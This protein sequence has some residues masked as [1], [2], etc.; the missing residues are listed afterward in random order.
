MDCAISRDCHLCTARAA[1]LVCAECERALPRLATGSRAPLSAFA[2][3]FPV[4]R[5]VQRFKFGGDL[6]VG[7]WLAEALAE[8][9]AAEPR[10]DLLVA[11]PLS[12]ARLR[13]RGFNQSLEIARV[14][15]QRLDVPR[16]PYALVKL[17]DTVPQQGLGR[18]A[19]RRNLRDAFRCSL[20]LRGRRVALID[21]VYTTG[22]TAGELARV[23]RRAGA[24]EV[25]VWTVARA[26][27][28]GA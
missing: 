1:S 2:Y 8:R 19:R 14:V 11:P 7:R 4:D 15:G 28:R 23:L 3:R 20:D 13:E 21:D 9:A 18:R 5:L 22:A 16:A 27:A 24:A 10:P 12:R 25:V 26:A 17:R 6:A